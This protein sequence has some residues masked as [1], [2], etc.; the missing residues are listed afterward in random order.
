M[1]IEFLNYFLFYKNT[2][3]NSF[4]PYSYDSTGSAFIPLTSSEM[5]LAL[6]FCIITV[7]EA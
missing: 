4:I 7:F 3:L 5:D 6:N 1:S 2:V